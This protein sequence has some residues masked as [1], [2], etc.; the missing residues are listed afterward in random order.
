M[1]KILFW[2]PL[3]GQGQTSNIHITAVLLSAMLKKRVLLMQ[4]QMSLNNLESPLVGKNANTVGAE[5]EL[6]QD[7]GMDM[8]MTYH[9]MGKLNEKMLKCCCLTFPELPLY[10]L[11]GT[12]IKNRETFQRDVMKQLPSFIQQIESY[13][14]IICIDGNSGADTLS[15]DLFHTVDLVIINLTQR[16][17]V[18]DS[19]FEQYK[20]L[21]AHNSKVFY[22][23][24][25]YHPNSS[26]NLY[27]CRKKY[28]SFMNPKNSSI[29]PYSIDYFNA[30]N[31]YQVLPFLIEGIKGD[32]ILFPKLH[33]FL[34][35]K[36]KQARVE[37][38]AYFMDTIHK[39]VNQIITY[40]EYIQKS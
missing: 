30:L 3:H 22:L 10:L 27:N 6:F 8:A 28:S 32:T 12:E 5:E 2:S 38:E 31:R 23:I 39:T 21:L 4:T 1:S 33:R 40:L 36:T 15:M 17:Y 24:G 16:R 7:I 18:L 35:S 29:I 37:D 11:P 14:D 9:R 20:D 25:C 34:Q 19:V 13:M 26:Y